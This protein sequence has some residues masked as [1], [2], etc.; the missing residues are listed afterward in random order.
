MAHGTI[1][2]SNTQDV[3]RGT[4]N[5]STSW[6]ELAVITPS[7]HERTPAK[8]FQYNLNAQ[9]ESQRYENIWDVRTED[10]EAL[11]LLQPIHAG[12]LIQVI[13]RAGMYVT[14]E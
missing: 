5:N 2:F 9:W 11:A 7:Y 8:I 14:C 13:P 6:F 12:D 1:G 10:S 3:D 4:H